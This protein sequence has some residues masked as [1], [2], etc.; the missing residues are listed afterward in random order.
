MYF[1]GL[2]VGSISAVAA[3]LSWNEFTN[4][5]TSQFSNYNVKVKK[6]YTAEDVESPKIIS[7]TKNSY[8]LDELETA[9]DY[10]VWV[11]VNTIDYGQSDWSESLYF[12]TTELTA[13]DV[14]ELT[15]LESDVVRFF[16]KKIQRRS[17]HTYILEHFF[18]IY[19]SGCNNCC[20]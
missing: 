13:S 20:F 11:S 12:K 1:V 18:N 8:D 2:N 6:R 15:Q 16:S 17:K 10:E 4:L 14:N 3:S 7:V 5:D 19:F 9:M